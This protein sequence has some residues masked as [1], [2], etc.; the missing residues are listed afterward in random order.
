MRILPWLCAALLL[1]ACAPPTPIESAGADQEIIRDATLA[2][3][4]DPRFSG[5]IVK[6]SG[7]QLLLLGRVDDPDAEREALEITASRAGLATVLSRLEIR[8]R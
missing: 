3:R 7:G 6:W 2:L 4:A 1:P 5:V 8:P